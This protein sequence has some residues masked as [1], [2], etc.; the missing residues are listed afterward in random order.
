MR[1]QMHGAY[2]LA[3]PYVWGTAEAATGVALTCLL[4]AKLSGDKSAA[5]VARRQRD[6]ILGCNPFGLSCLIGAG[7]RFPQSPHHQIAAIDKFQLNGGDDRR[8]DQ[9]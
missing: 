6:Y 2:G 5:E 4:Y 7:T 3:T 8:P 1:R 9:P